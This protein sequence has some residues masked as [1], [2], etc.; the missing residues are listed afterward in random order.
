MK[1]LLNISKKAEF[2]ETPVEEWNATQARI[3]RILSEK[4]DELKLSNRFGILEVD[5]SDEKTPR[6]RGKGEQEHGFKTKKK[7][8]KMTIAQESR[9]AGKHGN[10]FTVN[11]RFNGKLVP[12]T[13]DSAASFSLAHKDLVSDDQIIP[14]VTKL[15]GANNVKVKTLEY[16]EVPLGIGNR[17]KT[18]RIFI[19]NYS[20]KRMRL[21]IGSVW[22]DENKAVIN[23]R[24]GKFSYYFEDEIITLKRIETCLLY[25]SPS[26]R[27]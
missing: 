25:T 23:Y 5:E 18:I 19:H 12:A 3:C 24:H 16:A 11:M 22:L 1:K 15:V 6:R 13:I 17:E 2:K 9:Q 7:S 4:N 10:F 8:R 27:D 14:V 26:P 20:N 21:L